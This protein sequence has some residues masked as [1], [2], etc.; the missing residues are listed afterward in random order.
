MGNG[1]V[2]AGPGRLLA[3]ALP[4]GGWV[5]GGSVVGP[6]P[7]PGDWGGRSG[8]GVL[9]SGWP[10]WFSGVGGGF[11]FGLSWTRL[12]A[13]GAFAGGW[14]GLALAK[15]SKLSASWTK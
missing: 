4:V 14:F 11:A 9:C 12:L 10:P 7:A 1:L 6:L 8:H 15:T 3:G 2:G 13:G 5:W